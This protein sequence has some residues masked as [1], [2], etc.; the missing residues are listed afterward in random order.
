MKK[1]KEFRMNSRN[2]GNR[3]ETKQRKIKRVERFI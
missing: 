2:S 1:K 3:L